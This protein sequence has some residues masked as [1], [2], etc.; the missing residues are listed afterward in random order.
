MSC[1]KSSNV[2]KLSSITFHLL[3]SV[4][5]AFILFATSASWSPASASGPAL[6]IAHNRNTLKASSLGG[7]VEVRPFWLTKSGTPRMVSMAEPNGHRLAG[8]SGIQFQP[9]GAMWACTLNN[10][11]LKFTLA[12]LH[13]L[14]VQPHPRPTTIITASGSFGFIIGCKLDS[15]VNLWVVDALN[16]AVHEIS[17]AQLIAGS[18][19]ITP[20]VT[21]TDGPDLSS[22]AFD[23]FDTAGN[24]WISSEGNG[25]I[26]EFAANQLGTSGSPAPNVV[27]SSTSLDEPGEMDFDSSGN[28]WVSNAGNSTV[29]EFTPAQLAATGS[30]TAN[31]V[32]TIAD[33]APTSPTPWGLQF[34]DLGAL[35]VYDYTAGMVLKYGPKELTATGTPTPRVILTGLPFYA[36]QITFGPRY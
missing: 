2:G 25:K 8:V 30:P 28:L 24:L 10:T 14:S 22:P 27:I 7:P 18:A 9:S 35:W 31:V 36:S 32:L 6:W 17:H 16:D 15:H 4:S 1:F 19:D 11:V 13:N 26:V 34:D 20:A 12:Q 5:L 3:L 21:I 33:G 29:V 23:T